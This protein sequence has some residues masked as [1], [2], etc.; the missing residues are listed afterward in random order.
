MKC[1]IHSGREAVATC[2]FC[3]KAMCSD[4]SAY[5]GHT[6]ECPVCKK[7]EYEVELQS[8]KSRLKLLPWSIFGAIFWGL[9]L[10]WTVIGLIVG[11]VKVI[12]CVREHKRLVNRNQYLSEEIAKLNRALSQGGLGI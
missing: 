12:K 6:G 8:N 11:I 1:F 3:G 7:Q 2:R 9:L 10:C 5:T 4:C